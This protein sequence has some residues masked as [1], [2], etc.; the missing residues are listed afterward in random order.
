MTK[1]L[2]SYLWQ[3]SE[4]EKMATQEEINEFADFALQQLDHGGT[5][6]NMDELYDMWRRENPAPAA[7]AENVAA[8]RGAI[9][10]FKKG[11]RGRPAGEVSRELRENLGATFN[12]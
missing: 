9:D 10:D 8:V 12:E 2:E 7:Y 1:V 5:A 6:L 11:D 4:V 3:L